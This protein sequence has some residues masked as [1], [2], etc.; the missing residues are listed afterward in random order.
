MLSRDDNEILETSIQPRHNCPAE[1]EPKTALRFRV[2]TL[3]QRHG[4]I[5][6]QV[7]SERSQL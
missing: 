1:L 5:Q 7:R 6:L 4:A 2:G 3:C